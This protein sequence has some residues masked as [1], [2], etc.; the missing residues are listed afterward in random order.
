MCARADLNDAGGG[1]AWDAA[2]QRFQ[3]AWK[4]NQTRKDRLRIQHGILK[5][6][7]ADKDSRRTP[8]IPYLVGPN[9]V[10]MP[11]DEWED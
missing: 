9:K 8:N 7:R 6:Q 4:D 1:P 5:G 2:R 3:K 10:K 11:P